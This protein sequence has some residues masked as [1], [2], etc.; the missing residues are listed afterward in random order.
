LLGIVQCGTSRP[1]GGA[2]NGLLKC[3]SVKLSTTLG[4]A[5]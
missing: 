4:R 1:L 2:D 5:R 3:M